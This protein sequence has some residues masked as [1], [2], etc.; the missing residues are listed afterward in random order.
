M[1]IKCPISSIDKG[2]ATSYT[3]TLTASQQDTQ[4]MDSSVLVNRDN[5]ILNNGPAQSQVLVIRTCGQYNEDKTKFECP[6]DYTYNETMA[7]FEGPDWDSCCVSY[8][9]P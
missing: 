7:E 9:R 3:V 1:G 8:C 5:D 2:N 6:A 4:Y